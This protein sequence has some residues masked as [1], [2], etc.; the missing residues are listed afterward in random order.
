MRELAEKK[1]V[2]SFNQLPPTEVLLLLGSSQPGTCFKRGIIWSGDSYHWKKTVI[3]PSFFN[4]G[5]LR[6]DMVR[7]LI[8][9]WG[10]WSWLL[11]PVYKCLC[12]PSTTHHQKSLYIHFLIILFIVHMFSLEIRINSISCKHW[13]LSWLR[14]VVLGLQTNLCEYQ[15]D[16]G[17]YFNLYIKS[18]SPHRCINI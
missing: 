11:D 6:W 9:K 15:G 16:G 3:R 13:A 7:S 12:P 14:A 5:N 4:D 10:P 2:T 8:L 1:Q 18:L 17:F